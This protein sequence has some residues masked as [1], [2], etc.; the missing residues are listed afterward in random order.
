MATTRGTKSAAKTAA[1]KKAASNQKAAAKRTASKAAASTDASAAYGTANTETQKAA[2]G[3]AQTGQ[4]TK[5]AADPSLAGAV[6]SRESRIRA[7]VAE[8]QSVGKQSAEEVR[9][10]DEAAAEQHEH[11]MNELEAPLRAPT[12]N[13]M[14]APR[15]PGQVGIHP[16]VTSP[17]N[18][19]A[20]ENP[21]L[22]GT[23]VADPRDLAPGQDMSPSPPVS[24]SN[25]LPLPDKPGTH[26]SKL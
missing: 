25:I 7:A 8:Q 14:Q 12:T 10:A 22:P 26:F 4:S 3:Y 24:S 5:L 13:A 21:A 9:R 18:L 19:M 23:G 17:T 2:A 6:Q 16:D 11:V 20:A 15:E 1:E